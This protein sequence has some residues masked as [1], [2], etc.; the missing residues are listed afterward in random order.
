MS[1]DEKIL[2]EGLAQSMEFGDNWLV[3]V[4]ER[5]KEKFPKLSESELKDCDKLFREINTYAHDLVRNTIKMKQEISFISIVRFNEK[6]IAKYQWI[7]SSNLSRLYSQS[8]Y[9][10]LK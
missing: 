5:L 6:L 10:A 1:I 7:N 4:D 2:N 3:D 8:C 9:Y